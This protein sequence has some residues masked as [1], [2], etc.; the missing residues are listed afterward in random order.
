MITQFGEYRTTPSFF[1]LQTSITSNDRCVTF[2]PYPWTSY[3]KQGSVI[4]LTK[5]GGP[6]SLFVKQVAF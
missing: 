6:E 3:I 2:D 1:H 4:L 5:Y